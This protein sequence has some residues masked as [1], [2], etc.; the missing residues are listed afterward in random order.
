LRSADWEFRDASG[1]VLVPVPTPET[2][3]A[4]L[5]SVYA[6]SEARPRSGSA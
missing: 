5:A 6:L 1:E 3:V 4:A 2:K